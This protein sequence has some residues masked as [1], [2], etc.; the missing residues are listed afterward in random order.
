[1]RE[2]KNVFVGFGKAGKTLAF[3]LASAGESVILIEQSELM[4]GGTCINV[5]CI[6]SKLLYTLSDAGAGEPGLEKYRNA[7]LTK[8]SRI[9]TLRGKNLHKVADLEYATV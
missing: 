6:P 8:K 2:A 9:G 1:M 5:G 3:K 4:Y 7:V